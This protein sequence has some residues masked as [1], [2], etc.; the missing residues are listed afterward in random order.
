M[1][2]DIIRLPLIELLFDIIL[3]PDIELPLIELPDIELPLIE[4]PD[5]ELPLIELP[6]IELPLIELPDIELPPIELPL[7]ELPD[8]E[9]PPIEL[10]PIVLDEFIIIFEFDRLALALPLVVVASPQAIPNALIANTAERA[11]VFFILIKF[12]CLLLK[13]DIYNHGCSNSLGFDVDS[14]IKLIIGSH[15]PAAVIVVSPSIIVFIVLLAVAS[16]F[17]RFYSAFA[18]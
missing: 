17:I 10:P 9:L 13:I 1:L 12:S 2:F 11:K 5:I 15:R 18:V 4:L 8:I 14:V 3:L 6:D 16:A 7:I